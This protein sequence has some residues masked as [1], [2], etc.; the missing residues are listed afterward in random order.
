MTS[1]LQRATLALL[2]L[3]T[4]ALSACGG[5]DAAQR[6]AF[7]AF[8]QTRIVDKPGIHVPHPTAD[9]TK[10][11]GGYAQQYAIITGFNDE[12]SQ[13]V[14]APMNQAIAR[15]SI[16]SLQDLVT[17]RADLVEVRRGMGGIRS[18][19]DKQFAT[20]ETAHASLKQPPD[21]KPVFDAAYERDVAG[22]AHAFQAALPV[23][24]DAIAAA[25]D[26][27]DFLVQHHDKIILQG[28]QVQVS[29]PALQRDLSARLSALNAK[30][31][32][33]QSAQ[34]RLQALVE[35]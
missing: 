20:A 33:A 32:A 29:D 31:Q 4:A 35:G 8:L 3:S 12:L 26:L 27:G 10:A 13:H 18:D 14:T 17:R 15:G 23:A 22:P 34:Q 5:D 28:T 9:E 25:V 2:L 16:T 24:E 21:L 1:F 30:G 11:W 7:V 19:L 6:K